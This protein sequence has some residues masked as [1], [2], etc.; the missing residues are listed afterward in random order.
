MESSEYDTGPKLNKTD[1]LIVVIVGV[2]CLVGMIWG[3][4]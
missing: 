4:T 2:G 1:L 3:L